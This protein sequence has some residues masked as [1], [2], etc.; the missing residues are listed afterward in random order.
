[1]YGL[2]TIV[3]LNIS[4][5]FCFSTH[6]ANVLSYLI[7]TIPEASNFD[8]LAGDELNVF[9]LLEFLEKFSDLSM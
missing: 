6:S 8:Q 2:C 1:M 4:K 9:V 7:S 5:S 3:C